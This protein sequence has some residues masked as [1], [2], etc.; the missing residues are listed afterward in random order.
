MWLV[1]LKFLVGDLSD[2]N[3]NGKMFYES[4]FIA[5]VSLLFCNTVMTTE[6][7]YS[8]HFKERMAPGN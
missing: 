7:M 1:I 4:G 6:S 2:L 5:D 3:I 8:Y